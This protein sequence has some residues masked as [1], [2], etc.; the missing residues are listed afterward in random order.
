MF[1]CLQLFFQTLMVRWITTANPDPR[2]HLAFAFIVVGV[3]RR[4]CVVQRAHTTDDILNTQQTRLF[5]VC[6]G[7]L[8]SP[9]LL[10]SC[11][12]PADVHQR[13]PI[14]RRAGRTRI[15]PGRHPERTSRR[16]IRQRGAGCR[17]AYLAALRVVYN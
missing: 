16:R 14:C 4:L 9:P 3:H 2:L 6:G 7:S 13:T 8:A 17:L 5:E 15:C 10:K 12:L 1:A 11:D